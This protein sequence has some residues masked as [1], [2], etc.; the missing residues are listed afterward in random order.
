VIQKIHFISGLPRSGT[1]LLAALLRQNPRFTAAVTS[2]V[3]H[4]SDVM[5]NAMSGATEFV[6]FFDEER[7]ASLLRGVFNSYYERTGDKSVVFDTNRAWTGRAALLARLY[8]S[9]RIICCVRDLGWIIDSL[10][11][12]LRSN[13][14]QLSRMF[15]YQPGTSVFGRAQSLMH[16]EKGLIGRAW[17]TLREAW[18]GEHAG[19]LIVIRYETLVSE[20]DRILRRLY[21]VLEEPWFQHDL[22]HLDYDE[23]EYDANLGMPG[24]HRVRPIVKSDPRT[25]S[26]PPEIFRKYST[27]NFWLKP[28][29]NPRGVVVL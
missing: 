12:M 24:L 7:R 19:R 23:P 18:F 17:S 2:P 4:L 10:E 15:G 1:T 13:P 20:P 6:T 28:E 26:V 22:Q 5:T 9:A 14:M 27:S 16:P 25:P 8:P 11:R 21:A 29:T 3:A